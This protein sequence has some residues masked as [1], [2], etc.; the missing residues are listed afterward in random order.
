MIEK[1]EHLPPRR[2]K[3]Y[4]AGPFFNPPQVE[5]IQSIETAFCDTKVP[6][7]SPRLQTG[8]KAPGPI[9][10]ERAAE[11]YAVNVETL[12]ECDWVLAVL[13]WKLPE[14]HEL[15]VYKPSVQE[16]G[17][18]LNLPDTG[19]VFEMGFAAALMRPTVIY[20]ERPPEQAL[21]AMLTQPAIGVV[22]DIWQLTALLAYVHLNGF[23]QAA[24]H[25]LLPRWT[26][27]NQ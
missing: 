16:F 19:T 25:E 13:D 20:T 5:L 1:E 15:R 9:T 23:K 27:K 10:P 21:N 11:I 17:P 4:I 18:P 22:S 8:N 3:A 7:F 2:V 14:F 12:R 24:V 6:F 26:G